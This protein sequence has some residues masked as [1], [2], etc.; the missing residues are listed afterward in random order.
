MLTS[1][2]WKTR[3][4]QIL[5]IKGLRMKMKS[6]QRQPKQK[7]EL[8]QYFSMDMDKAIDII[9]AMP[10]IIWTTFLVCLCEIRQAM[11]KIPQRHLHPLGTNAR[12]SPQLACS[13]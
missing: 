6:D 1:L 2:I 13:R 8:L 3:S 5:F 10:G 4:P 7:R 12:S 11:G 9:N